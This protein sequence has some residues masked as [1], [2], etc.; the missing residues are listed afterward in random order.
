MGAAEEA[1]KVA[2]GFMEIMRREPQPRP[3]PDESSASSLSAISL[4]QAV[5]AQR[6]REIGLLY[7][8]KK[9]RSARTAW[10]AAMARAEPE[11]RHRS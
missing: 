2:G 9:T 10:R 1:G 6:E 11:K 8:D 3:G 4:L 7:A 5:A